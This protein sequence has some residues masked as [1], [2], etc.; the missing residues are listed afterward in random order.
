MAF[1]I[2]VDEGKW[3]KKVLETLLMDRTTNRN[4]VWGTNDYE[5]L[6]KEYN[7]HLPI[8][9]HLITGDNNDVI[10]PRILKSKESQGNRTKEKAEVFTPCW[11]CNA[12]NNLVDN[13]WFGRE[14]VFNLEKDQT[15]VTT[16][17]KIY[18][19]KGKNWEDYVDENRL[20]ITCGE[21]PYLVSRYDTVTG[22]PI[23]LEKRIGM[24]DRKMRI[25]NENTI[26]EKEWIKWAERA[27]QSIYGF[28]FQGDSLL[29]ARENLL[30]SYCDYF[31]Q[32]LKR[33]PEE[34]ELLKIANI[35]SWNLWQ[36]V[37]IFKNLKSYE[38]IN[39]S[40]VETRKEYNTP[41][42]IKRKIKECENN[43][44]K[45]LTLTV[46]RMLTG[47][48]VEQWDTM[49]Y[50]KDTASPQEYDQS[51][52]RLQN[53]YIRTLASE[54]GVIKENL[55]PQTLLVD[56]DPDRLFRMQEQKSLIYNVN[57]DEN[58]NSKLKERIL[59]E[60]RI[61][62]IIMMNHNKIKEVDATNILEAVSEY[63]NQRS[64]SEEVMDIPTDLSILNDDEVRKAIESQ[65]EF[66]SK[67]GLTIEPN[68]GD[69][70]EMDIDD[71]TIDETSEITG[72]DKEIG[73]DYTETKTDD[74][75][76]KL[77]SKMK[78]Y[79]QRLL[80]Y[81]FLTKDRVCSIDDILV[82]FDKDDNRRL[83]QN[84]FLEKD[85]LEKISKIMDPF[86]RSTLD[87]KIQNI[88]MLASDES[89]PP[90]ERAM[91]SIKK[92]NRMS[93]SEVVTPAKVC[94]EM[95]ALLPE[96]G[97]RNIVSR[98]EKLLDIASKSGEYAV[99]LYKRLTSEL[100]YSHDEIK[101][102][103][104]SIPTSSVAYEFTRRFY[105]ILGLNIENIATKFNAYDLLEIRDEEDKVSFTKID[106]LLKQ[107][108]QFSEITLDDN[109]KEGDKKMQF[110]AVIGNPPYQ[111]SDGGAQA[112][113]KPIYH[114]FVLMGKELASN[115]SCYITPTRWFAG[116]KGLDEFRDLMLTDR[117]MRELHDFLTPE[118][119]FPNTNNRGGV[120]YFVNDG[121]KTESTVRVVTHKNN[122]IF[123]DVRRNLMIDGVNIFIRD[124]VAINIIKKIFKD[125]Y[126][127][128]FSSLV[129][130]RKPFGLE[131]KIIKT[132]IFTIN[133][134][135][136]AD[137]VVCI[138]KNKCKGYIE[139]NNIKAHKE[140]I[141]KWKVYVPRANNIGTELND[142]NLNSFVGEPNSVCTE[143]YIVV[144]AGK[145]DDENSAYNLCK[146]LNSKFARFLHRQA[147]ASQD[148]SSKTYRFIPLENF[149]NK[150]D[151]DWS[152][153]I[154]EI[155]EQLF[156]K[157]GLS[158][159]EKEHIKTSIK[160]M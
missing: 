92:F 142:D 154:D 72:I 109:I 122:G 48:T 60:L 12:Q 77:E 66:N 47:S 71:E 24:L 105:E 117:T 157:Y 54:K 69:G 27:F 75:I 150:S 58:G 127:D 74:E 97:L 128:N 9:I 44:I 84:L 2:D 123:S 144:G 93:E 25:V 133:R 114:Y 28:E 81:A 45:T 151:I 87:Y 26:T 21:A 40:G 147:K 134:K 102:L 116:G 68:Q 140:W 145:I 1:T 90:L 37:S 85:V 62:P 112:S 82:V 148:A 96:D 61:S 16:S 139:K 104:Y 29:I 132:D 31:E 59:E 20:E 53:Q 22:E 63:N 159:E 30:A 17:E 41:D 91:N 113:A 94:D 33:K 5:I 149:T 83:A 119:V 76:K 124:S 56:F 39:I 120:C 42:D 51:I 100:G 3:S 158:N 15:W 67:K 50:F 73:E 32:R 118:D 43:D 46:N 160:D 130:S 115:Y 146:Y 141:D 129:S 98:Q 106:D 136:L 55:K 126:D 19:P 121:K 156:D 131:S 79:Y 153:S 14:N 13:A 64:V 99:S 80:F 52:F 88:S 110:G 137:P 125:Y 38:I 107:E 8:L 23:E 135:K 103:I 89:V 108:K 36:N 86:K 57:T 78:T 35:I 49:L 11:V 10:Q 152:K 34:K 101:D 4:I 70:D 155:D 18:F 6:G 111:I 7:S 65:A 95:V 143:A 138:G